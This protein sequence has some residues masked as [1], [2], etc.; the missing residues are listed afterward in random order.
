MN[1]PMC[2]DVGLEYPDGIEFEEVL[3]DG[4]MSSR[5][6]RIMGCSGMTSGCRLSCLSVSCTSGI[7]NMP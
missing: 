4:D 5:G 2:G 6:P 1:G 7:S 3:D